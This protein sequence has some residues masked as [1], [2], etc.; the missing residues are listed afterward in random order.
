MIDGRKAAA[1]V[2]E[3]LEHK[4]QKAAEDEIDFMRMSEAFIRDALVFIETLDETLR[5]KSMGSVERTQKVQ[6]DT[7]V[8]EVLLRITVMEK[9]K[10]LKFGVHRTKIV[11]GGQ[12][13]SDQVSPSGPVYSQEQLI[14]WLS[15]QITAML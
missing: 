8:L 12:R 2:I 11:V 13:D 7:K 3:K 10:V 15:N 6:R 5:S 14:D 4:A 9:K 1:L